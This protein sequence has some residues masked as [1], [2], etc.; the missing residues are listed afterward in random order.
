[1]EHIGLVGTEARS[2]QRGEREEQENDL[3]RILEPSAIHAMT[4]RKLS[5]RGNAAKYHLQVQDIVQ[6]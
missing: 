6:D 5:W 1:M 3:V 2:V 4:G